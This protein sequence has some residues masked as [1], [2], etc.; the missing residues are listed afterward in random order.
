[1]LSKTLEKLDWGPSILIKGDVVAEIR[2]LKDQ[3]RPDLQVHGSG[4]LIQ[5]LL[6]HDLVD[7]LWLKTFPVTLGQ[8]KRL[9]GAGAVPDELQAAGKPDLTGRGHHRQLRAGGGRQNGILRLAW[10]IHKSAG[11]DHLDRMPATEASINL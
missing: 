8:G 4:D 5:T 3:D 9:F 1:M 11:G 10:T 2:K 6:K 7:E